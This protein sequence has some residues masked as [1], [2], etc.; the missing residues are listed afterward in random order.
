MDESDSQKCQQDPV[1][2]EGSH[3]FMRSDVLWKV[4]GPSIHFEI[5]QVILFFLTRSAV[6]GKYLTRASLTLWSFIR[7]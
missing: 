5:F 7:T 4:E 2:G 6:Q 1:L 3:N